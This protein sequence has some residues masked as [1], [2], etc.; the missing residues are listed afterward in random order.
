MPFIGVGRENSGTIRI[1]Y[2]DRGS[3]PPVLLVHGHLQDCSAW[4][5]QETALLAAGYRVI[6]YD[7]RGFGNSSKPSSGYDYTTFSEDLRVL[8]DHLDLDEVTLVGHGAGTG[9]VV[10]YLAANA[11]RRVRRAA[12]VAPL[13]PFLLRTVGNPWGIERAVFDEMIAEVDTDR[14]AAAKTYLDKSYNVDVLSGSRISDQAWQNSF[15]VAMRASAA[16]AREGIRAW[17]EDF[18]PD[19]CLVRG[20]H[21]VIWTNAREVNAALQEFLHQHRHQRGRGL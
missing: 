7:R 11:G 6:T 21:A 14:P 16:A 12:L 4:E 5:K 20:P 15:Q 19:I 3:G 2:E 1:H 8:L 10:R 17:M 9:D 18:R 13:P